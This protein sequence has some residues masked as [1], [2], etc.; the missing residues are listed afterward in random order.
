MCCRALDFFFR[1]YTRI[2]A[3]SLLLLTR[4]PSHPLFKVEVKTGLKSSLPPRG[5]LPHIASSPG[6]KSPPEGF[7]KSLALIFKG[8]LSLLFWPVIPFAEM[9]LVLQ[10]LVPVGLHSGFRATI[11]FWIDQNRTG[12]PPARRNK[13][14]GNAVTPKMH[15]G[16]G[17]QPWG[18]VNNFLLCFFY[19]CFN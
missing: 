18:W 7:L 3:A 4:S 5:G 6:F 16:P 1:N 10:T 2:P 12:P 8:C 15:V 9:D 14:P 13:E 17:C 11:P 19:K